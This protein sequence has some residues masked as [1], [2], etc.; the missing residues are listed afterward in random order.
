MMQFENTI[1]R[2]LTTAAMAAVLGLA[3]SIAAAAQEPAP[4]LLVLDR[5]ALDYGDETHLIPEQAANVSIANV[6]LRDQLPFFAARKGESFTLPLV[7]GG[8]RGWFALRSAPQEWATEDGANDG[9]ENF[10]LAGP[11]LGSPDDGGDRVSL[12]GSVRDVV[13]LGAT[14]AGYLVGRQVCA[15]VYSEDVEAGE[16]TNL[17]G[18]NLGVIA[19]SVTSGDAGALDRASVTVQILDARETCG[20]T[21]ATFA[22]APLE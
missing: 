11:G 3:G 7:T 20:S 18:P 22:E 13:A 19:F 9:A 14:G 21:I 10:F 8:S 5:S 1:K 12:L 6:G 2:R 4:V 16:T 15:V 17:V